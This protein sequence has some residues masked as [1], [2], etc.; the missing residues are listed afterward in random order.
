ML[1][2]KSEECSEERALI[3]NMEDAGCSTD[4][5]KL[6]LEYKENCRIK[7]ALALLSKHRS[8]LLDQIHKEQKKLD[9]L[10]YLIRKVQMENDCCPCACAGYVRKGK[11]EC[12][13]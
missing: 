6:F 3:Q 7:E 2:G 5:I 8:G 13:E 1:M 10:D 4:E 11:S 9:C 12:K